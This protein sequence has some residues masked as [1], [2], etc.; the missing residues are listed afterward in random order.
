MQSLFLLYFLAY[1][2]V[3]AGQYTSA[4][5]TSREA[6]FIQSGIKSEFDLF[7]AGAK[8]KVPPSLAS[9][10]AIGSAAYKKEIRFKSRK[11]GDW[12]IKKNTIQVSWGFSW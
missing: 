5:K 11:F 8:K 2:P 6:A 12:S 9:L 4:L 1:V 3:E 7:K 10:G